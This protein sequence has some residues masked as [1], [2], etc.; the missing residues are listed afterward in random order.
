MKTS[1]IA[2]SLRTASV[3]LLITAAACQ[4]NDT[5]SAPPAPDD[6]T[7]NASSP[8]QIGPVS[9]SQRSSGNN[10]NAG[11]DAGASTPADAGQTTGDTNP[12]PTNLTDA[13]L[14]AGNPFTTPVL[15]VLPGLEAGVL[16]PG[17][18]TPAVSDAAFPGG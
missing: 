7:E 4:L 18:M 10:T 13:A 6:G 15:P 5:D 3:L 11:S 12:P 14:E 8:A 2:G 9:T 17:T 16:P 1:V